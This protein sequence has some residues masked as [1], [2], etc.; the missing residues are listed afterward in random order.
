[1]VSSCNQIKRDSWPVNLCVETAPSALTTRWEGGAPAAAGARSVPRW[2]ASL[3][4]S[5]RRRCR[6]AGSER[7]TTL[8][9]PFQILLLPREPISAFTVPATCWQP[10]HGCFRSV[11]FNLNLHQNPR[12]GGWR[13]GAWEHAFLTNCRAMPIGLARALHFENQLWTRG[14]WAVLWGCLERRGRQTFSVKGRPVNIF[15]PGGQMGSAT[16]SSATVVQR[17]AAGNV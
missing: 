9:V 10:L 3:E 7:P 1:M 2:P 13:L 14:C 16:P 12:G 5:R 11:V 6:G 15:G 17:A 4:G 8:L